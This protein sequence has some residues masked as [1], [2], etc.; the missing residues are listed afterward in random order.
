MS[1]PLVQCFICTLWHWQKLK[2]LVEYRRGV[3]IRR[4]GKLETF[5]RTFA[6]L[7]KFNDIKIIQV[8][9]V[10]QYMCFVMPFAG[11]RS[12]LKFPLHL[13]LNEPIFLLL[14]AANLVM[15][16]LRN[17]ADHYIFALLFLSIYLLLLF[18]PRLISAVIGWMS[19]I[20]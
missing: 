14:A 11:R 15:V 1:V 10:V 13:P 4:S 6:R 2:I 18:F 7:L 12:R 19:T 8:L 3:I 5:R 20:L 17:R 16:A 9:E